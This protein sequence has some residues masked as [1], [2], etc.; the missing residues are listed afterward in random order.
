MVMRRSEKKSAPSSETSPTI[1]VTNADKLLFA[2]FIEE[3]P[4]DG[5]TVRF[6]HEQ[7][8]GAPFESS[9]LD[10]MYNFIYYWHDAAHE[11]HDKDAEGLRA[12]FYDTLKRFS[13]K[14]CVNVSGTHRTGWLSMGIEDF[15]TRLDLLKEREELN[16]M[17]LEA[18]D[19]YQD[20]VRLGRRFE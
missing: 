19:Q 8:I 15:E 18:Y 3:F 11:F 20:I 4:P 6:L 14:L 9:R 7:D 13:N 10:Q 17:A 2:K 12:K 16:N 1:K 5:A